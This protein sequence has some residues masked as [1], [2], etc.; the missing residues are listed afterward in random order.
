MDRKDK[1]D[2]QAKDEAAAAAEKKEDEESAY[3]EE[4]KWG[5]VLLDEL[6]YF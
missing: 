2:L 5:D 6:S 1:E 4:K 3:N